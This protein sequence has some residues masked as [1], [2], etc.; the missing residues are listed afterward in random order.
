[1]NLKIK[2]C[3]IALISISFSKCKNKQNTLTNQSVASAV[4]L[5]AVTSDSFQIPKS[6]NNDS[7]F[8]LNL[9]QD[10]SRKSLPELRILRSSVYARHGYCFM[11]ADLRGYFSSRTKWY[12]TLMENQYYK[13]ESDT[14]GSLNSWLTLSLDEKNFV[15]KTVELEKVKIKENYKDE[16]GQYLA[17][18]NNVVN[19]FQFE[20]LPDEFLKKLDQNNFAI[21]PSSKIQLFHGYEENDYKQIPNFVTTDLY[22]QLF[23]MYFSYLMKSIE[24]DKLIP[25]VNNLT[26][27]IYKECNKIAVSTKDNNL[28][29]IAEYSYVYAA[30][31]NYL[32]TGNKINIPTSYSDDFK[33]EIKNINLAVDATSDFLECPIID[34]PYSL[35]K[36]RGNYTRTPELTKYFKAMMW[37]Q[38]VPLCREEK[39]QLTKAVFLAYILNNGKTANNVSLSTLY[40]NLFEPISFLIGE[41]DNLSIL[42]IA[43]FLKNEGVSSPEEAISE[44]TIAK[45]DKYLNKIKEAKNHIK[46]KIQKTCADKINFI[47]QR[48]LVDNEILQELVDVNVNAARAY[49]KGLDIFATFGV[50]LAEN[51]L[52]NTY[53]EGEQWDK[54]NSNL[55]SL[56][57][58][59]D[60][61]DKWN[62]AVYNKWLDCLV[63]LNSKDKEYP[64][65]M[66]TDAWGKKN[67]NT[68]LASWA[69]LKHDAI[70]YGE[71]PMA[72]ECGGGGPPEPIVVGYVEPNVLFWKKIIELIE[73][74]NNMLERNNLYT[75]DIRSKTNS[76]K[77]QAEFL[78]SASERELKGEQLK[79]QEYWTLKAIGASFE[80]LTLSLI[81]PEKSLQYWS[82]VKGPDKSIAVVADIYTR[83]VDGCDK[84]GIL[85]VATGKVN[86]IYAIVNIGG[87]LY[88]TKGATFCY[89]EFVRPLNVRLTDEQW[90]E[91]LEK[92]ETPAYPIWMLD[93]MY[94]DPKKPKADE[95]VFYSSGC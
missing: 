9:S 78:L 31:P 65:F 69:E 66:Q 87:Y 81:E 25:I 14:G 64:S 6:L 30:V 13:H 80:Y 45:V 20:K 77:E 2:I 68:A 24:T 48:Y 18:L 58:K 36:P 94:Q 88:L 3:L 26:Q 47:P 22:L 67:L 29:A 70:L 11:E 55:K 40:Q 17:N 5:M 7:L 51:I 90:Q 37:L 63:T 85:H 46:P 49:P 83:N 57:D 54:Y 50:S 56:K 95:K 32:L 27:G 59:F 91:I 73:L 1:M 82:D 93:I 23:H 52:T 72:A 35:F 39:T 15:D 34:F 60:N 43:N 21:I 75:D 79:E 86:D 92:K 71:Q 33:K 38:L 74:T 4:P 12:D 16:K 8:N 28:K 53:K 89:F 62:N 19:L 76:I 10:L 44:K 84:N 42:D 61:Y 41:P